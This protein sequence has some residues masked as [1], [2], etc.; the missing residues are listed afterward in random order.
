MSN[1]RKTVYK[2]NACGHIFNSL[3]GCKKHVKD[4]HYATANPGK[5]CIEVEVQKKEE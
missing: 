1:E 3:E 2:C 5:Y 4:E